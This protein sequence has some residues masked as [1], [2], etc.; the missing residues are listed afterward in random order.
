MENKNTLIGTILLGILLFGMFWYTNQNKKPVTP[1]SKAETAQGR[2]GDTAAAGLS[3]DSSIVQNNAP[4]PAKLDS[5]AAQGQLGPFAADANGT[6]KEYTI[7]NDVQK[8]TISAK[9]GTIKSVLLKKYSTWDK[10]PLYLFTDK[11]Q[12]FSYQFVIAGNRIINTRNLYFE[13]QSLT[14]L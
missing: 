8:I 10:K 1:A 13:R 4:E 12:Q 6:D 5:A 14:S 11:T 2:T 3:K 7:E 9:G